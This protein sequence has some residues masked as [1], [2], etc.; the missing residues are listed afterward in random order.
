LTPTSLVLDGDL[1]FTV[2][3]TLKQ[4]QRSKGRPR[5]DEE[6]QR[7]VPLTDPLYVLKMTEFLAT[8][9]RA[10]NEPI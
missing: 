9:R 10:R 1:P 8:A 3:R 4:R 2:L 5:K 6:T 7:A